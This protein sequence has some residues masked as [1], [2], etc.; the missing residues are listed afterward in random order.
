LRSSEYSREAPI[1]DLVRLIIGSISM[2]VRTQIGEFCSQIGEFCSQ[3]WRAEVLDRGMTAHRMDEAVKVRFAVWESPFA[4]VG[5]FP[6][7]GYDP[8][9]A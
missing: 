9:A 5:A 7:S 2:A 1:V 3:D 4:V 8:H 6:V